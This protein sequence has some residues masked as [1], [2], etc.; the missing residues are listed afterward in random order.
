MNRSGFY[1]G[2]RRVSIVLIA[3]LV[4][5]A[6]ASAGPAAKVSPAPSSRVS[7]TD[8]AQIGLAATVSVERRWR[9]P[10]LQRPQCTAAF[11]SGVHLANGRVLT[12]AH[13]IYE[14]LEDSDCMPYSPFSTWDPRVLEIT[15]RTPGSVSRSQY[16][17][18]GAGGLTGKV[19]ALDYHLDLALLDAPHLK[20]APTLTWGDSR[21]L[22]VGDGVVAVGYPI[23]GA[24]V[25]RGIVSALKIVEVL[26]FGTVDTITLIQTDAAINPGNSGGP[27]L[28]ERGELIG[29][30][31]FRVEGGNYG[32]NF[33][34]AGV[35]AEN[36]AKSPRE[37]RAGAA[38]PNPYP[39]KSYDPFYS[40]TVR[41][42]VRAY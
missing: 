41:G 5:A 11:G 19:L 6:C 27:L 14:L 33:A 7:L 17:P 23:T 42:C 20:D 38:R 35:S 21:A 26:K 31:D 1:L 29:I 25:T 13:L 8:I 28:N 40:P 16:E 9:G 3:V 4:S 32:L 2:A 39:R 10:S 15:V 36:W 37:C 30:V 34:V 12:A 22:R 24:T 18:F